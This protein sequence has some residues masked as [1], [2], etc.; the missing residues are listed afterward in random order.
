MLSLQDTV[1]LW[2]RGVAVKITLMSCIF[3]KQ[4]LQVLIMKRTWEMR[5]REETGNRYTL[6]LH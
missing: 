4:H 2:T 5:E 6:H 1:V 3:G